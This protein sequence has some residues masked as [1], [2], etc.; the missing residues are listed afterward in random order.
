MKT[1]NEQIYDIGLIPVIKI[2]DP[3]KAVPLAKA[4]CR[5]G[6][7]AAEI[8]FRTACAAEAIKAIT[9]AVPE[10]LVGAGTVLTP[11]QADAAVAAGSKFIVSPGLNPNVVKHC[12]KLGVPILPGCANPSDIECALE[13]G[14]NTVKFFPAEAAGGLPMIKAMS[15]PYGNLKF[16][17]TGG[18][19]AD[20]LLS[21]LSFG[22]IIACG[23]SFMV[24]DELIEAGDF[25]AIE[26]LT[27]NAVM[28]ML[29]FELKHV[30][31][32]CTSEAEATEA[33]KA[34]SGAFG[35]AEDTNHSGAVW[36]G[37]LFEILK[38]PGK[39]AKGHIAIGTNFVDRAAA[40]LERIGVELDEDSKKYDKNG[41]LSVVYLKNEMGGFAFHLMNK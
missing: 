41:K 18:I 38:T 4:L 10:M 14:L 17:P 21:Y 13:L 30:G 6:L 37:K 26:Q 34:I 9:E 2:T 31:I 20:N 40:Y 36:S 23:G 8:T 33:M 32:N 12:Q 19:N 7:P 39:G 25:D 35:F 22:K 28:K 15:A 27:R 11:E 1:I 29:G 16:M 24:K 5:G 3:A